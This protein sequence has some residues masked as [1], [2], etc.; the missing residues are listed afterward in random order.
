MDI[1]KDNINK[2]INR[3]ETC[4]LRILTGNAFFG[5]ILLNMEF[6]IDNSIATFSC[7]DKKMYY[8]L[9]YLLSLSDYELDITVLHSLLHII[10]KHPFRNIN[11]IYDKDLYHEA[12]D[13]VVNSNILNSK[14][15]NK[16]GSDLIVKGEK[17]PHLTPSGEEG[18]L[19]SVDEIY[20]MLLKTKG[21][22]KQKRDENKDI[23]S[24][25]CVK[26][27]D[28]K[29]KEPIA[30][31]TCSEE[32]PIYLVTHTCST[33]ANGNW[34]LS[35]IYISK[36]INPWLLTSTKLNYLGKNVAHTTIKLLD[37]FENVP[38]ATYFTGTSN[39]YL[40]SDSQ[41][42]PVGATTYSFDYYDFNIL[43]EDINQI[44]A[45]N[46]PNKEIDKLEDNYIRYLY[47]NYMDVP[48]IIEKYITNNIIQKNGFKSY[49]LHSIHLA[50][51]YL[52]ENYKYDMTFQ[53]RKGD[54]ILDFLA[55]SKTGVCYHFASSLVFILRLLGFP[56]RLAT[57]LMHNV[58]QA[59]VEETIIREEHHAWV[60]VF[61]D[62][63][64]WVRVET[65]PFSGSGDGGNKGK[66]NP[67]SNNQ[68]N[69]NNNGGFDNHDKWDKASK[70]SQKDISEKEEEMDHLVLESKNVMDY[71]KRGTMPYSIL[72]QIEALTKA[73]VNWKEI[74]VDFIQEDIV[75]YSFNPPDR[76]FQESMF[77]LP[78]YN[79]KDD[80]IENI[81]FMID[82][83]GSMNDDTIFECFNEIRG[84][85][86]QFDGK[87][88]GTV[89]FFSTYVNKTYEITEDTD[90]LSLRPSDRGGTDFSCIFNYIFNEMKDN[91]PT[92]LVILTD[93][94]CEYPK[95]SIAR[96]IPTLWIIDNK[97]RDVTPPWGRVV[98]VD[99]K[100]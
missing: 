54:E 73:Q 35:P 50:R 16:V 75:D 41:T 68:N 36:S 78:D 59:N 62:V 26:S 4:R 17:L 57:G 22:K 93:G 18:H 51:K 9:D 67:Q 86:N 8:N 40:G 100:K 6:A 13:I 20:E 5:N 10:L 25:D 63:I 12:C 85:M 95:E 14:E 33:Y 23:E 98:K 56:A 32:G 7:F 29:L 43:E 72:K 61:I 31:I 39:T 81:L 76:R 90:I 71:S 48:S 30:K 46:Y 64:G 77:I 65:T 94:E 19:Y 15:N 55:N 58:K 3:L 34:Y 2:A 70:M 49:D 69:N 47:K 88:K 84:A 52:M 38:V 1:S 66:S 96:G 74:L 99:Y 44:S 27:N 21:I 28:P 97:Y 83:S 89:G 11:N 79:V 37:K 82:S 42:V 45:A 92:T 24:R 53:N 60:E 80:S 91:L 87:L